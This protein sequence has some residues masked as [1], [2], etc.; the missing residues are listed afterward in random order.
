MMPSY[1]NAPPSSVNRSKQRLGNIKN[2]QIRHASHISALL[3]HETVLIWGNFTLYLTCRFISPSHAYSGL[4]ICAKEGSK[5]TAHS[6]DLINAWWGEE[7]LPWSDC[8]EPRA[9]T[10]ISQLRHIVIKICTAGAE[11]QC[12]EP[13][14]AGLSGVVLECVQ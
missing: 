9:R 6:I 12:L 11:W 3:I 1:M 4:G 7:V 10:A 5:L 2:K 14:S 8:A 13:E